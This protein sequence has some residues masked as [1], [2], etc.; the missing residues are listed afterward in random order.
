MT[1]EYHGVAVGL[2]DELLHNYPHGRVTAAID[3]LPGDPTAPLAD[4]LADE[5]RGRGAWATRLTL[6]DEAAIAAFRSAG[7]AGFR[8]E[9]GDGILVVDGTGLHAD[10]IVDI[11]NLSVWVSS[12]PEP[13]PRDPAARRYLID[14]DPPRRADAVVDISDPEEAVRRFSDWCVVPRRRR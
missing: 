14:A 2:A 3:A 9:E 4:A 7:I 8:A 1:D 10:G 5:L 13:D 11:W 12:D 6:G